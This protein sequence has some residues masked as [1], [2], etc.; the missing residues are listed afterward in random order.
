[1]ASGKRASPLA[2]GLAILV[3]LVKNRHKNGGHYSVHANVSPSSRQAAK[4]TARDARA[5]WKAF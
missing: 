3:R 2:G 4:R 5:E 1:M